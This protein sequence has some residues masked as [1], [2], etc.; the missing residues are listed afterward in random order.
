M[1]AQTNPEAVLDQAFIRYTEIAPQVPLGA[2]GLGRAALSMHMQGYHSWRQ[3]VGEPLQ[4]DRLA[5]MVRTVDTVHR[6]YNLRSNTAGLMVALP[7]AAELVRADLAESLLPNRT[8]L[9]QIGPMTTKLADAS[10]QAM[11]DPSVASFALNVMEIGCEVL[12]RP[13]ITSRI[14]QYKDNITNIALRRDAGQAS[15]DQYRAA[16]DDERTQLAAFVRPE[17]SSALGVLRRIPDG[18]QTHRV[19]ARLTRWEPSTDL[20]IKHFA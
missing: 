3:F 11:D 10:A 16:M 4:G 19:A 7:F 2:V 1:S 8:C 20:V 5:R 18:F 13:A 14:D 9:E 6:D 17:L 12:A 15:G